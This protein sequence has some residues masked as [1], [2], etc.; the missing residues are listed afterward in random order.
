MSS[1]S[2]LNSINIPTKNNQGK[3]YIPWN[4]LWAELKK[5]HPNANYEFHCD[6]NGVPYFNSAIGLFV[7]VSVTVDDITHT[8]TRPVYNKAMKSMRV[9][10]YEYNT[11]NGK[12]QVAQAQADDVND[13]QMRCFAKAMAMHGLGLF[14]FE[15]KQYADAE[16]IDSEQITSITKAC[17]EFNVELS[18]VNALY[19]I[20]KLSELQ[21]ANFDNVIEWIKANATATS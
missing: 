19:G 2:N 21:T 10:P 7:K 1:F 15:D 8:M 5:V 20:N 11:K 13:A 4:T 14:V 9:E 17:S 6:D 18:K 12:K 16:L 3:N